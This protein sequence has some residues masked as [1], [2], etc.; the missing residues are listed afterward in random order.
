MANPNVPVELT[1]A[2]LDGGA[3]Q[4]CVTAELRRIGENIANPNFK[5]SAPRELNLKIKFKPDEKGQAAQLTYEIKTKLAMPEPGK[6]M[7]FIAMK[8][9]SSVIT[10]FEPERHPSLYE[11]QPLPNISPLPAARQA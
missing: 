11:D 10:F 1:L 9:G 3:L 2:T 8:P 7:A 4:E 6:S 5:S